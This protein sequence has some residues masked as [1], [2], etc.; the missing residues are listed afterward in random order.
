MRV[1]VA[2]ADLPEL[3][4]LVAERV[5]RDGRVVGIDADLKNVD[6][7]YRRAEAEGFE[8]I[9]FRAG[10]LQNLYVDEPVD[11]VIGRFCLMREHDP[12]EAIRA[13]ARLVHDGGRIV[14]QE[15]HFDS[16]LW[17]QTSDWPEIPLYRRFARWS[18]AG[19][20]EAGL[21]ADVGLRLVNLFTEAGLPLP[22][23]RTELRAVRGAGSLGYA[24]FESKLREL[25]AASR[26]ADSF[27]ERLERQTVAAGGHL[28]LPLQ[29]GA[30]T[31]I[32]KASARP[33]P[34]PASRVK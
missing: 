16:I 10:T 21:H 34:R 18:V 22:G 33:F 31:R 17:P 20:R 24:F 2:G 25:A 4:L 14:F 13:A 28:F 12:V 3:A 32:V 27:A 1:L 19:M 26:D 29:V 23:V 7:A 11:A 8:H 15:W 6:L 5:G 30:W 9:D